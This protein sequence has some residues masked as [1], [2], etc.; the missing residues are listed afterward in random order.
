VRA[1]GNPTRNGAV[2]LYTMAPDGSDVRVLVRGAGDRELE[3]AGRA[4]GEGRVP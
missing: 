3:L 1:A 4:G 2:A